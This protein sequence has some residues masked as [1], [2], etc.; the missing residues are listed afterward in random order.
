MSPI[1]LE[2]GYSF[3]RLRTSWQFSA[4]AVATLALGIGAAC[5]IF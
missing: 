2:L 5:S 4:I 3:R 1:F